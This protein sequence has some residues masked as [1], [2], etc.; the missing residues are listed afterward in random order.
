MESGVAQEAWG[1]GVRSVLRVA[2]ENVQTCRRIVIV[3][4]GGRGK[5]EAG[6]SGRIFLGEGVRSESEV[7]VKIVM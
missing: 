3:S 1:Q 5:T 4:G 7:V 2:D 6:I